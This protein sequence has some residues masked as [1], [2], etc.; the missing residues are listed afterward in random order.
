MTVQA[1]SKALVAEDDRALADIIRMALDRTGLD[2][3][4]VTMG[5]GSGSAEHM[6]LI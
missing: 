2:V 6:F 1:K 3:T 5:R 4:V